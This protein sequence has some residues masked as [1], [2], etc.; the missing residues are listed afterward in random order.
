MITSKPGQTLLPVKPFRSKDYTLR[1]G[2]CQKSLSITIWKKH[3]R[4]ER[5]Y[6]DARVKFAF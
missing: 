6:L 1:S 4:K 2:A 3:D 5:I